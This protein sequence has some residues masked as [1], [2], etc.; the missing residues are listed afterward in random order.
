MAKERSVA[1]R[2]CGSIGKIPRAI[3]PKA[4][5]NDWDVCPLFFWRN[6]GW[7]VEARLAQ[8][9]LAIGR[10]F[11][12]HGKSEAG[13]ITKEGK[14]SDTKMGGGQRLSPRRKEEWC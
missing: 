14:K 10:H 2:E 1:S 13:E 11:S 8:G 4:I 7:E 3:F 6:G 5:V 12:T 9:P